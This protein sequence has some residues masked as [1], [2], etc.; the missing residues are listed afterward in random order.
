M[1]YT[2][3][4]KKKKKSLCVTWS[5]EDS[6]SGSNSEKDHHNFIVFTAN[7]VKRDDEDSDRDSNFGSNEEFIKTYNDMLSKW[8]QVC[9]INT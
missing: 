8:G 1:C 5:D 6:S 9:E 3:K 7:T 2:P 4:K